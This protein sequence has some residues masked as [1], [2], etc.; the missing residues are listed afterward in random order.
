[1]RK[2]HIRTQSARPDASIELFGPFWKKKVQK[3]DIGIQT[4]QVPK[5]LFGADLVSIIVRSHQTIV[6]TNCPT[7]ANKTQK[8]EKTAKCQKQHRGS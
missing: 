2:E 6:L 4:R 8:S 3:G 1:V 7:I 5:N